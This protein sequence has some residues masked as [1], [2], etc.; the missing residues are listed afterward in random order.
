MSV[1]NEQDVTQALSRLT[2]EFRDAAT[3]RRFRADQLDETVKHARFLFAVGAVV[4]AVFLAVNIYLAGDGWAFVILSARGT[5]FL[6]SLACYFLIG[7]LTDRLVGPLILFWSAVI[8]FTSA[9]MVVVQHDLALISVFLLPAFYYLAFPTHFRAT[10]A[11]GVGCSLVTFAAYAGANP[12]SGLE[13][14]VALALVLMNGLLI[15]MRSQSGRRLRIAWLTAQ[16]Y[17][18]AL[19]DLAESRQILERTFMAVPIP[20][21]V[22]AIDTGIITRANEAAEEFLK[23]PPGALVGRLASEFYEKSDTRS[24]IADSIDQTD[25]VHEIP[26][27]LRQSDGQKRSVLLSAGRIEPGSGKAAGIVA[28]VVDVTEQQERERQL[29]LAERE[30]RALF[31]NAVV[32]IYRSTPDGRMLRANPALVRLNGYQ[33]EAELITAVNDI[34]AEWYVKPGRREEWLELMRKNGRVTDFVSEVYRHKTRERIW[35]SENSWTIQG[36]SGRHF[37]GTLVE[38]TDRKR[39]EARIAHMAQHDQLTDLA[40]RRLFTERLEQACSW[41]R[42]HDGHFSV[43]CLDLDRFKVVNDAFGHAA[44]DLLLQEAGRRL[45]LACRTEDTIAR[46][47]GDEFTVLSV[48]IG[49]PTCLPGLA[50]RILNAFAEPFELDGPRVSIG[51]SIGIVVAPADGLDPKE[52]LAR[53]DR[54][55]YQ[56]KSEGR[57]RFRF[58]NES[59][60]PPELNMSSLQM[61]SRA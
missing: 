46:M 43:M 2:G 5:A 53:A 55:L 25:F 57:N 21:T 60:V 12:L 39:L 41:V 32:G 52:L 7:R 29:R 10:F 37:E 38:A 40:N 50:E 8:V 58:F 34:A 42:R 16:S 27:T 14:R 1:P 47:G 11:A 4:S 56:A 35:I 24:Q 23:V 26:V 48:G 15:T 22:A 54:A 33:T 44:G 19:A 45:K 6:V 49:Y 13:V 59:A 28:S 3:E 17:K 51:I 36:E 31:E 18:Q 30:Y 20:L 61:K 9:A